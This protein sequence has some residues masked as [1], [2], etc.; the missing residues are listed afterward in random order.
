LTK[1]APRKEVSS[2]I[3][4]APVGGLTVRVSYVLNQY[5]PLTNPLKENSIRHYPIRHR[6]LREQSRYSDEFLT[7]FAVFGRKN[8]EG[9]SFAKAA[10]ATTAIPV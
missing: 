6:R 8:Q 4:L 10:S 3:S 2:Q 5:R 7:Q 9:F 1:S